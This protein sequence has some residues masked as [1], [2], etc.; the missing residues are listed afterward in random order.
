MKKQFSILLIIIISLSLINS[1]KAKSFITL[2]NYINVVGKHQYANTNQL[3]KMT[4]KRKF[5]F[6]NNNFYN[7]ITGLL[8]TNT[9]KIIDVS[10]HQKEINWD[11]AKDYIDGVILRIGYGSKNL[12][13]KFEQYINEIKKLNIPY[14]IYLYSYAENGWEALD[15]SKFILKIINDYN[16]NPT[17]G[18]YYD[19]EE[20]YIKGEKIKISSN[21]YEKVI[22]KFINFLN[23]S[24]Y[25][26]IGIYTNNKLYKRKLNK[27]SKQYV[28]WLAQYNY[29]FNYQSSFKIWQYTDHGNIPGIEENVDINIM[30][31]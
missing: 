21:T 28:T 26:N 8:A 2:P 20:F 10:S 27:Q 15:E 22:T 1:V 13:N 25:N 12:D 7:S 9:K 6:E 3:D 29:Y 11:L 5:T 14:G 16:L 4:N 17:L 23:K 19:I 30:F 31:D 18:I 24:G